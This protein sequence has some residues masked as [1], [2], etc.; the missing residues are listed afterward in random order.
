[1]RA[2]VIAASTRTDSL[3]KRLAQFAA[4]A[5]EQ[6]G[7]E[8]TLADLRD[9]PMPLYDGDLEAAEGLPPAAHDLKSL[10]RQHDALVIASPEYNGS[11]PAVLKNTLDWL[12]RPE[13]GERPGAAFR[14]KTAWIMSASPGAGGGRRGLRHLRDVLQNLGMSVHT[15]EISVPRAHDAFD[16]QGRLLDPV[17]AQQL[18]EVARDLSQLAAPANT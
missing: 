5:L 14:G 18:T 3:N 7:V 8:V 16:Q 17:L 11:F 4:S 1:M 13:S 12:S 10:V 15:V 2:L 9:F 6:Q